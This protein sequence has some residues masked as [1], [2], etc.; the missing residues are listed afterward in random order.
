M[1]GYSRHDW[2]LAHSKTRTLLDQFV[3]RADSREKRK[4][5][6]GVAS[7]NTSMNRNR[8][9]PVHTLSSSSAG[10]LLIAELLTVWT[11]VALVGGGGRDDD[12]D[13]ADDDDDDADA[14]AAE[15]E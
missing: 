11:A 13:D 5:A 10:S 7:P 1:G 14:E 8:M 4:N 12:E 9:P 15:G 2:V 6:K 3:T